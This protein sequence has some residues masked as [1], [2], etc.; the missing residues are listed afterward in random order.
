MQDNKAKVYEEYCKC[1]IAR[2]AIQKQE[3]EIAKKSE[4]QQE[5]FLE[6]HKLKDQTQ[7]KYTQSIH[8]QET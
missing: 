3:Q 4:V 2:N 1:R 7:I 6:I 8:Y 5:D